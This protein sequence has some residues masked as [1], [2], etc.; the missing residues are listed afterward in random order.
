MQHVKPC[1][2][3]YATFKILEIYLCKF[4]ETSWN[5]VHT[6]ITKCLEVLKPH[7]LLKDLV[8]LREKPLRKN[9]FYNFEEKLEQYLVSIE[10]HNTWIIYTKLLHHSPR[11]KRTKTTWNLMSPFVQ[12]E[13]NSGLVRKRKHLV[14]YKTPPYL[15]RIMKETW[16]KLMQQT[17]FRHEKFNMDL[18]K[19]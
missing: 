18:W 15:R 11:V 12:F 13:N 2:N 6:Q 3:F 14:S 19:S 4:L 9:H 1:R 7:V 8:N 10:I 17:K 5:N 16:T